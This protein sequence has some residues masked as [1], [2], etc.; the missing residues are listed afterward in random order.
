MKNLGKTESLNNIT[1]Y[2]SHDII[3]FLDADVLLKPDNIYD[4][5]ARL[6]R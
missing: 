2:V 5:L 1:S 3:M 4:M 6:E